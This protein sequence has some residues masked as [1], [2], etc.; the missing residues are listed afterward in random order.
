MKNKIEIICPNCKINKNLKN[1]IS[2]F[3]E[4]LLVKL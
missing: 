3:L 1:K 2:S 4:K